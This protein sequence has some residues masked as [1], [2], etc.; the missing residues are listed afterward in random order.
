MDRKTALANA[1]SDASTLAA[2]LHGTAVD[3]S[4]AKQAADKLG[5]FADNWSVANWLGH[6]DKSCRDAVPADAK[7]GD[8]A[9]SAWNDARLAFQNSHDALGEMRKA[10]EALERA[11]S[12]LL[13]AQTDA[14][15]TARTYG[16][17]SE[18]CPPEN[19]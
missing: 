17:L 15:R 7:P 6:L 9:L 5:A 8:L 10:R 13:K 12:L 11:Y 2:R 4:F 1:N 19:E 16:N 18:A 3:L 14:E